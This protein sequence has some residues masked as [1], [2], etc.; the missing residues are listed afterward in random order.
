M[1]GGK[2]KVKLK[3]MYVN[4]FK[5]DNVKFE[6][7]TTK[8]QPGETINDFYIRLTETCEASIHPDPGCE[9]FVKGDMIQAFMEALPTNIESFVPPDQ[10]DEPMTIL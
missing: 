6:L 7:C 5:Y 3:E 4:Y 2:M 10:K 8:W 9:I 1:T